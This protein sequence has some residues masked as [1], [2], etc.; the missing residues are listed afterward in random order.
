M[1]DPLSIDLVTLLLFTMPGF[2]FVR[3]FSQKEKSDFEYLMLSMFWGILLIIFF[4][5]ILPAEKFGPLLAN[6]HAGA[7]VFSVVAMALGLFLKS[8]TP[9]L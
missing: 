8:I 6:P 9:R 1:P 5:K 3:A 7:V 2:F 4:Y